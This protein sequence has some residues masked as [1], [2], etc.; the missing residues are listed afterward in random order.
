MHFRWLAAA[1]VLVALALAGPAQAAA[2]K[3]S[4]KLDEFKVI[5]KPKSAKAG[6]VT[7]TAKNAGKIVHELVVLKTNVAPAKLK[8]KGAKAV[9]K[10]RVGKVQN[11]QPGKA[12]K[13]TLKLKKG[14][15]VLLCNVPGHY[16]AGQ[17]IGFI[18]K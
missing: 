14:K 18:V 12:K 6:K 9:E 8:V 3:V 5:P 16:Q 13:L 1:A 11:I 2:P 17:R 4:V 10:G 15:Y 7:F